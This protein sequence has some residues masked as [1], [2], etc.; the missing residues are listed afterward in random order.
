MSDLPEHAPAGEMP[1]CT[2]ARGGGGESQGSGT[3]QFLSQVFPGEGGI[4]PR[5]AAAYGP[6]ANLPV[7]QAGLNNS[8]YTGCIDRKA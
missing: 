8:K 3:E 5:K 6:V 4:N 2:A 7:P 1:D